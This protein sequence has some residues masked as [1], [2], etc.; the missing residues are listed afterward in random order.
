MPGALT[1]L[2]ATDVFPP[3]CGGSGWS[4]YHLARALRA[5]GHRVVVARPRGGLASPRVAEYD[6]LPVHEVGLREVRAPLLRGLSKQ[7][8]FWPRFA[9][10]LADLA[11]REGADLIHGQHLLSI[12][13]A[14]AAGRAAGVPTVATVRDYWPTCPIGTRQRRCPDQAHCSP[15]CQ[16]CCLARGRRALRPLVRAALPYVRANLA[17]R[18]R[19]LLKADRVIAVSNYVAGVLHAGIPGLDP[20]V[21]PNFVDA[22][23]LAAGARSAAADGA[24]GGAAPTR[25]DRTVLYAGKLDAHKGADLLP[26]AVAAAAGARLVVAGDGPLA[27]RIARE[28]AARGVAVELLGERPNAEVLALMRGAAVFLFPARWEEPLSRTLLEAGAAGLPVVALATGGTPDIVVDGETGVLVAAPEA[29][30]PALAS[31]LAD[32]AR[33]AALGAAARERVAAHF[34]E[35]A[36]VPRVEALY[37]EVAEGR[38]ARGEGRLHGQALLQ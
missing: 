23:T 8:W 11:R 19:A 13:A 14:V 15:A 24:D 37:R 38:G 29:L 30:G 3:R 26:A 16:V 35:D 20:V 10:F 36:V 25:G 2:L 33:R 9:R 21:V 32:P 12:P 22:A 1:V 6:G 5:R 18:Q 7:E 34:A 27:P 31:L 17:R 28:C 4:T